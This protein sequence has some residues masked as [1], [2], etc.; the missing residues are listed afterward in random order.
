MDNAA[1]LREAILDKLKSRTWRAGH[2]IPTERELSDQFGLSRSTVRRVLGQ[3]KEKRLI[4]QTVG[5]GTYV[6][7]R[8]GEALSDIADS[9]TPVLATS[10][11]ELM[12]ARLVLEPAIVDMVI[13]SATP[14]DF[15]RMDECCDKAEAAGTL[16]DFEHW[17]GMLH[18][19]I[20]MAA[21]NAFI[22]NVFRLMNQV[23]AQ[24][25]WGVLKRRSATPARRL[26]Y[27]VEHR[28]LVA[29]L[30]QRDAANARELCLAHLVHV[31]R[32]LL[33]S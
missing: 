9:G 6:S 27:Q 18:E 22:S 16:E 19:V 24:G 1:A 32:N 3:L 14:A 17:D 29:A 28:A 33:G 13:V 10:P 8:V 21:H 15:D 7:E 12:G 30:K 31:R 11:A 25:E 23:R 20:A 4:T 5:S 2:R 26:E